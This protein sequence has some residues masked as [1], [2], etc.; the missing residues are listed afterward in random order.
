MNF[1]TLSFIQKENAMTPQE[2]KTLCLN[3]M[4]A[5]DAVY[6]T[7]IDSQGYPDTRAM[8]NLRNPAQY[9]NLEPFFEQYQEDLSIFFSTN[10]SSQKLKEIAQNPKASA[11]F[12]TP[13]D[14]KGVM[15]SGM[16]A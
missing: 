7:T 15:L 14:F 3:L 16:Y 4:R 1:I 6:V 13:K 5:S 12:C 9:P 8:L 10:T 2:I 11:Y